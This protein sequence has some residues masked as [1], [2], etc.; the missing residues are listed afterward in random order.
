MGN[1]IA[2]QAQRKSLATP[3]RVLPQLLRTAHTIRTHPYSQ[4]RLDWNRIRRL[5]SICQRKIFSMSRVFYYRDLLMKPATQS[6]ALPPSLY[7]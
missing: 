7:I 3:V 6:V 1:I 5:F 4:A 2:Y